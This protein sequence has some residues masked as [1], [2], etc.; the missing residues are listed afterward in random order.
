MLIRVVQAVNDF[1]LLASFSDKS[2]RRDVSRGRPRRFFAERGNSEKDRARSEV[3]AASR[4]GFGLA[5]T[6]ALAFSLA[7]SRFFL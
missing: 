1:I 6:Y 4:P 3:F 5:L 7:F 2:L